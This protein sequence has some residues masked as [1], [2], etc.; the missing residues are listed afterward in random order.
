[1]NAETKEP[2]F[3]EAFKRLSEIV[4][5]LESGEGTL[6]EMTAAFEEGVALSKICAGHLDSIEQKVE[7]LL[8]EGGPEDAVPFEEE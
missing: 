3:E 5:I 8:G 6:T 4:D 7:I 2:S 1:M